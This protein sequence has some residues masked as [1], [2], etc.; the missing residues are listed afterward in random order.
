MTYVT[1]K[2]GMNKNHD[3]NDEQRI[4]HFVSVRFLF[5][6][7][8]VHSP[9]SLYPSSSSSSSKAPTCSG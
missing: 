4:F 2:K 3:D 5:L 7:F 6:F 8:P 1:T 9:L